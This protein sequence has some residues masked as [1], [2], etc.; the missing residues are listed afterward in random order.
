[1]PRSRTV[2]IVLGL[3]LIAIVSTGCGARSAVEKGKKVVEPVFIPQPVPV[4]PPEP[5]AEPPD[6]EEVTARGYVKTHKPDAGFRG[7]PLRFTWYLFPESRRFQLIVMTHE[8]TVLF[9]SAVLEENYLDM[10]PVLKEALLPGGIYFWQ[11]LA[12]NEEGAPVGRSPL[13]DFLYK[14]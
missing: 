10:P 2:R 1:M 5:P 3:A 14:P 4:V 9:E 12:L 6:A 13:R 11:V 7:D 8:E